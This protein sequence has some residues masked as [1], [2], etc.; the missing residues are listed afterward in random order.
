VHKKPIINFTKISHVIDL[1]R[2]EFWILITLLIALFYYSYR[3]NQTFVM[4]GD[5]ARDLIRVMEI[6]QGKE[7]TVI[8][9]PVNTISNNPILAYFGSMHYYFGIMGLLFTN[10]NPIGSVFINIIATLISIPFYFLLS[11]EL[12]K[13]NS[14][15]L[16]STFIY[17]LSPIT[18]ALT[19]SYWN[20]NLVIPLSVIVWF[21]LLYDK[22]RTKYFIAGI[23]TGIILNLHYMNA[24]PIVLYIIFLFFKKS[25]TLVFFTVIGFMLAVSPL[26]V[27]EIKNNFFLIKAFIGSM[28]GFSTFSDR[29]Y[30]PLLSIDAFAYI[31]GMGPP[32]YFIPGLFNFAFKYRILIDSII[33]TAFIFLLVKRKLLNLKFIGVV[34]VGLLMCWY[35]EKW[36]IISLRYILSVYPLLII[37]AV[38]F[39]AALTTRLIFVLMIPMLILST[40]II[41]HR[42]NPNSTDDYYPLETVEKISK[43]I[44]DDNPMG[45][46]NIT[47]NILGDAQS[48][49]IRYFLMRDAQVKPQS[50]DVYDQ[51]D[52][53]YVVTP[54]LD[55]AYKENRWE[56]KASGRKQIVWEK[57][58][59]GLK[60]YKFSR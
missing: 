47:E 2:V 13:K 34:L 15:S 35:F 29:T 31:F 32:Q 52:T 44:I 28:G 7:I 51:I 30:N 9:P 8:G 24:I 37:Y 16:L 26:I 27:F 60:L 54:S 11:K 55:K 43:T 25:K 6:W 58:I 5:T 48:L 23:I 45:K 33:G 20:P 21:L 38:S 56:F 18:V 40:N 49:A 19:R 53:L 12:L 42:L 57:N 3:L 10:F 17:A 50:V 4:A 1:K 39:I 41:T 46:Y 36:H 59:E 22:S 14:L